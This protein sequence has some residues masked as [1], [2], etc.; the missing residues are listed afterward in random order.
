MGDS[1][2]ESSSTVGSDTTGSDL[3]PK[4]KFEDMGDAGG[5]SACWTKWGAGDNVR[6]AG[7]GEEVIEE[8]GAGDDTRRTPN[9]DRSSELSAFGV[10]CSENVL[11]ARVLL[12][13]V[14][15]PMGAIC[16]LLR[17]VLARDAVRTL[18]VSDIAI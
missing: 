18:A 5:F 6:I 10:L 9:S 2:S 17:S 13:R 3:R 1:G 8:A 16:G 15:G 11:D 4:E 12:C 14:L 7:A